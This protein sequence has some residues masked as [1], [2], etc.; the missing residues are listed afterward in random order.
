MS[1]EERQKFPELFRSTA[2]IDRSQATR[3]VPMKVLVFGLM[4]TGTASIRQ[5]LFELGLCDVYHMLSCIQNQDDCQWWLKALDAKYRNKGSFTLE[6]WDKLLG[7]CQAVCDVPPAV[8]APELIAAYPEA[9][10]IILNRDP[11]KWYESMKTTVLA[12]MPTLSGLI[13]SFGDWRN[14]GQWRFMAKQMLSDFFGPRGTGEENAKKVFVEYHEHIRRIVPKERLLEFKVQD[15]YG[16]LCEFLEV[17]RPTVFRDGKEVEKD[18][19]RINEGADFVKR[20]EVWERLA[21]RRT[22]MNAGMVLGSIGVAGLCF[23]KGGLFG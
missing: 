21:L 6:D 17:P 19:P 20:K 2:M 3:V 22:A 14:T 10:V 12:V 15:G 16:P 5:A 23:W 13:T 4:R 9:K 11:D 18:F 1:T 7:H 8:F